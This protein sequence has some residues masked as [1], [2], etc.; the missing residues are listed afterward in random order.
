MTDEVS[1]TPLPTE[2]ILKGKFMRRFLPTLATPDLIPDN[3]FRPTTEDLDGIS[4]SRYDLP[5]PIIRV[6]GNTK[7]PANSYSVCVFETSDLDDFV[8][9]E[10]P[11]SNDLGHAHIPEL[12]ASYCDLNKT[13]KAPFKFIMDQLR[14]R[15]TIIH[16]AGDP[17][18]SAIGTS[19]DSG[20]FIENPPTPMSAEILDPVHAI[21]ATEATE[22]I[23]QRPN[24]L[25]RVL[26]FLFYPFTLLAKLLSKKKSNDKPT[27]KE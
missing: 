8:V 19:I 3:A 2:R 12:K 7:K 23:Q 20:P 1:P 13:Q 26:A 22:T 21:S 10:S 27:G 5:D 18:P 24:G 16:R 14:E 9:I 25:F 4:V 6:L 15:S 17:I 11:V